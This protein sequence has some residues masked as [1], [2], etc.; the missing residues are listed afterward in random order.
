MNSDAGFLRLATKLG[1]PSFIQLGILSADFGLGASFPSEDQCTG[2]SQSLQ[3]GAI[4]LRQRVTIQSAGG[5]GGAL[6]NQGDG[7]RVRH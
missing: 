3:S 7:R 4:I 5:G 2:N 1:I 6:L